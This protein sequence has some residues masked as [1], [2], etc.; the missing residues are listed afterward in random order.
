EKQHIHI[1]DKLTQM[2]QRFMTFIFF[3]SNSSTDCEWASPNKA[4]SSM[5]DAYS[6]IYVVLHS[7]CVCVCVC[8]CVCARLRVCVCVCVRACLVSLCLSWKTGLV[9][10][11]GVVYLSVV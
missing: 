3:L 8:V 9:Q 7:T 10:F 11:H 1:E 5:G 6:I 2:R 4:T